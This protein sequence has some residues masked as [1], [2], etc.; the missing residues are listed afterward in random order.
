MPASASLRRKA[1]PTGTPR[2][3]KKPS[4]A[5][6]RW[7]VVA[8]HY[9]FIEGYEAKKR[10]ALIVSVDALYATNNVY[11]TVMITTAGA[12]TRIDDIPVTNRRMAGLPEN[13]VIRV[14]RLTTLSDLQISHRTG[15]ITAKDRNSVAALLA[16]YLS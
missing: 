2:K 5:Y 16:K 6:K 14:P 1:S 13:C 12:G 4:A 9:P 15:S 10:P 8:V 7:D 11:W 3:P